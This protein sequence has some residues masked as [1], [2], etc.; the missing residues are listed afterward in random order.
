MYT[1]AHE[2][3]KTRFTEALF[4]SPVNEATAAK[5]LNDDIKTL[6][7]SIVFFEVILKNIF[8]VF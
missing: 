7:N 2:L 3:L 4:K 5:T 1:S 6:R 8:L